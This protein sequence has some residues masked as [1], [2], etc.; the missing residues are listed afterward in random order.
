M[1]PLKSRS[2]LLPTGR[3]RAVWLTTVGVTLLHNVFHGVE[4]ASA[5]D[6]PPPSAATGGST[7]APIAPPTVYLTRTTYYTGEV[8]AGHLDCPTC[9][10][11]GP[12]FRD[13]YGEPIPGTVVYRETN[14]GAFVFVPDEPLGVGT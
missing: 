4:Q 13:Q 7:G 3:W 5:I 6:I 2:K 10:S 14:G 9:Y 12:I 8:I 11:N 1:A